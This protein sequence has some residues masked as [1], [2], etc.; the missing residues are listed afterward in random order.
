MY[1]TYIQLVQLSQLVQLAQSNFS[2]CRT[3]SWSPAPSLPSCT[4]CST[5]KP[6]TWWRPRAYWSTQAE[7]GSSTRWGCTQGDRDK[8]QCMYMKNRTSVEEVIWLS[9]FQDDL[10]TALKEGKIFAAGLDVMTPE[11]LPTDHPLTQLNNCVL[12]SSCFVLL[13]QPC[14]S[15]SP[16]P[17]GLSERQPFNPFVMNIASVVT[18]ETRDK[19]STTLWEV[20]KIL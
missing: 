20:L 1:W 17:R 2:R 3:L 18:K 7:A 10:V 19:G 13:F 14:I 8:F 6:S 16:T 12:V 9:L 4:T 5:R 15:C 11:P